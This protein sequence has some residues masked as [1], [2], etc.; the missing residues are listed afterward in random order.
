[1][2]GHNALTAVVCLSICLSV[3]Y[4]TLSREQKGIVSW[5]WQEGSPWPE[6]PCYPLSGQR[7]RSPG[8]LTLWP[9]IS[10][11]SSEPEDLYEL[12]TWYTDGVR[13]S[14][15]LTCRMTSEVKVTR[16]AAVGGCWY[17]HLQGVGAYSGSRTSC[18]AAC[19]PW[20]EEVLLFLGNFEKRPAWQQ[21]LAKVL[22]N[23]SMVKFSWHQCHWHC[24][25][26]HQ[27]E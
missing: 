22:L 15:S 20:K 16:P 12:Q 11:I 26:R 13:W 2:W 19:F 10:C 23:C 17:H 18:C 21:R 1:M 9:K 4:M 24:Y 8:Y 14:A 5:Q 27:G 6:W 3:I 7:W 25:D